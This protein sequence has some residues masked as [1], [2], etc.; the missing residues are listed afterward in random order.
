[1]RSGTVGKEHEA[2]NRKAM[3]ELSMAVAERL[4]AASENFSWAEVRGGARFAQVLLGLF[5][6]S[7]PELASTWVASSGGGAQQ[8]AFPETQGGVHLFEAMARALYAVVLQ[9]HDGGE[10][11]N[12]DGERQRCAEQLL[13]TLLESAGKLRAPEHLCLL[14]GVLRRPSPLAALLAV[15]PGPGSLHL[16]CLQLLQALLQSPTLFALA[17]QADSDENPLLAAANLLLVPAAEGD[18]KSVDSP[19]A[20]S[21]GATCGA[22]GT[23]S[24]NAEVGEDCLE[25]QQCSVAALELFCRCLAT[26]PTLDVVL[27]LRGAS[28]IGGEP[29]DTVLQRV[30]LLCH[31][32]LLC[33]GLHGLDGGPWRDAD[34]QQCASR[35]LRTVELALTILSSFVWHAAPWTPD[36]QVADG[37]AA[38]AEACQELGRTRPLLASIVDMVARRAAQESRYARLLS[39]VSSLRVLLAHADGDSGEAVALGGGGGRELGGPAP[40]RVDG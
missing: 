6:G 11:T 21:Q 30:V 18:C 16:P 24:R 19:D 34:L 28:A 5:P 12:D 22:N 27:Q 4:L 38:R 32:E 10:A 37:R 17:H 39:S 3:V 20:A 8:A 1:M 9:R 2:Q 35:R 13:F 14:A 36:A 23:T 7:A 29:V 26:A 33:L 40:M 25:R 31:H 15:P